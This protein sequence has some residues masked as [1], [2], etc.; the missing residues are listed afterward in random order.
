MGAR[1]D[2]DVVV[3]APRPGPAWTFSKQHMKNSVPP[4]RSAK[5]PPAAPV[6]IYVLWHPDF[7][8]GENL[9]H[10]IHRWFRLESLEG[11]PVFFRSTAA[12]G[13]SLP[14]PISADCPLNYVL[15]LVEAN[16]VADPDWRGYVLRMMDQEHLRLFPVALDTFAFQMPPRLRGLNFI[17]HPLTANP[18]PTDELLLGALTEVLCRDLRRSESRSGS[19]NAV[20]AG[21][22]PEKIKIFLSHA[23]A[24]GTE[25]PVRLKNYIQLNTQCETFFDETDIASGHE[26]DS[27]LEHAICHES[28]GMIAVLGDQYGQRPWCRR[29][30]RRF[31]KPRPELRPAAA[32]EAGVEE[33]G[34][35]ARA[36]FI[37]PLV[38]VE[39]MSGRGIARTIPELGQAPCLRWSEGSERRVVST[40]LREILLGLFY[41]LLARAAVPDSAEGTVVVNRPPDPVMVQHLLGSPEAPKPTSRVL[42]PGYG[43][44]QL[45]KDGLK[46]IFPEMHFH[47]L[48]EARGKEVDLRP[49]E[50]KVLRLG[51]GNAT[52]ILAGGLGDEHNGE[53]LVRLMRPLCR[54]R[55]SVLYGGNIPRPG[56]EPR[57]NFTVACLHLL[58]SE[59]PAQVGPGCRL[60]RLYSVPAWDDTD[61][62]TVETVA[63]WTD[64]C[65][66]HRVVPGQAGLE[67]PPPL[68][69]ERP[70]ASAEEADLTP[71][72]RLVA[73][74]EYRNQREAIR[75]QREAVR[76]QC[77]TRMRQRCCEGFDF[78]LPDPAPDGA[79]TERIRPFAHVLFG[80]RLEKVSGVAPGLFEEALYA[81]RARQPVFLLGVG[82]GAAGAICR[83]LLDPPARRPAELDPD[84]YLRKPEVARLH[85]TLTG[86]RS[87][88]KRSGPTTVVEVLD[89]LWEI[90]RSARGSGGISAVL[91]NGLDEA[92]NRR[93]L[94]AT[95]GYG[96]VCG[97]VWK[98]L[99]AVGCGSDR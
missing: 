16:M 69:P 61:T 58:L 46:E 71:A 76:A 98:G 21:G 48:S 81:L 89:G 31:Q 86:V 38:V 56:N 74:E 53:L 5:R 96:E 97:L 23:K 6:R 90:V 7:K 73:R 35:G 34:E 67:V 55:V 8:A 82:Y 75:A 42:Y 9:A 80:G 47:C 39:N 60:A 1:C 33:T 65:S 14:L 41:R 57:V 32:T 19:S 92:E 11:I 4:M 77:L 26:F 3:F 52:D 44:S 49:L 13:Q 70:P 87:K 37:P 91:N 50:G 43:I 51:M 62:V 78:E 84:V 59:R 27:I 63:E 15:P 30:V 25:V 79:K 93:L 88:R 64:V 45:E 83:W 72:Q 28:A 94:D 10:A 68:P 40:L 22:V 66:F 24:D 2:R 99:V 36:F 85:R 18:P 29:E 17:R 20:Q 54:H 95:I 12:L